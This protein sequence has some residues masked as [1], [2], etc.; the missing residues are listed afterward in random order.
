MHKKN[1]DVDYMLREVGKEVQKMSK[2]EQ[3]PVNHADR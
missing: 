3:N 2:G 1:T